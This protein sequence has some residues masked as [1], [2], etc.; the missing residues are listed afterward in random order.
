[1]MRDKYTIIVFGGVLVLLAPVLALLVLAI[2]GVTGFAETQTY[3][4]ESLTDIWSHLLATTLPRQFFTTL[5]LML[6]VGLFTS[7]FGV[8]AAWFM[9][10]YALPKHRWFEWLMLLPL[11]LPTYLSVF[12]LKSPIRAGLLRGLAGFSFDG[13]NM[14]H[15]LG[16]V[17]CMGL[18]LTPLCVCFCAGQ[19]YETIR[20]TY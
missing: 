18:V 20:P 7:F 19:F 13:P 16:A 3:G 4:G 1:M 2:G 6:G 17:F 10:F 9:T 15:L 14:N 5:A 8:G 11:A 12:M